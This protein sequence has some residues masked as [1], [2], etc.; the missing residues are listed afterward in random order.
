MTPDVNFMIGTALFV[1]AGL[2][3]LASLGFGMLNERVGL[4]EL[5]R[6]KRFY[7]QTKINDLIINMSTGPIH[8]AHA[9]DDEW[10]LH[11]LLYEYRNF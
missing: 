3:I 5:A 4:K 6:D 1:I 10:Q 7:Y 11:S 2:I 9:E 8:S